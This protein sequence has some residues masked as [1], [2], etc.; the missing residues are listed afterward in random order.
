VNVSSIHKDEFYPPPE[1]K[2]F[3]AAAD[4]LKAEFSMRWR[5]DEG[6]TRY[7]RVMENLETLQESLTVHYKEFYAVERAL[8]ATAS[9]SFTEKQRTLLRWLSEFSGCGDVY[10]VLIERLSRDLGIPKSTVRWNLRRLRD[11][12]VI[13]AGDR[14]NKGIPVELTEMGRLIAG[15]VSSTME[16]TE[17][18]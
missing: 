6:E 16:G 12:G 1:L 18:I 10:T 17:H 4:I 8:I 14:D 7:R 13:T 5:G 3:L 11:S 15:H 9:N 2:N